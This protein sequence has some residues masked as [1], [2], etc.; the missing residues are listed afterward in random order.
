MSND[1]KTNN[2]DKKRH[3]KRK[4]N[5]IC[6]AKTKALFVLTFTEIDVICVCVYICM[7]NVVVDRYAYKSRSVDTIRGNYLSVALLCSPCHAIH[8]ATKF[9]M[10]SSICQD[11][12]RHFAT[13]S[14]AEMYKC[15]MKVHKNVDLYW[16][17]NQIIKWF[18]SPFILFLPILPSTSSPNRVFVACFFSCT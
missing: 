6:F 5:W 10:C 7:Q 17:L 2:K 8:C 18:L 1:K 16:V 9:T 11:K 13:F 14:N 12:R 15:A 3:S 4:I